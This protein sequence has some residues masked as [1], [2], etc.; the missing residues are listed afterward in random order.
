MMGTKMEANTI[1]ME[2]VIINSINVTPWHRFRTKRPLPCTANE[3]IPRHL[4]VYI[5]EAMLVSRIHDATARV[6]LSL[7]R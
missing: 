4:R 6:S 7:A 5:I 3:A 1:M 2:I